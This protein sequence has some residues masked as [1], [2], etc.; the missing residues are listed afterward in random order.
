[1]ATLAALVI[2]AI[3]LGGDE[4]GIPDD[5]LAEEVLVEIARFNARPPAIG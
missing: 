3:N 2:Q 4:T 5:D 1:M